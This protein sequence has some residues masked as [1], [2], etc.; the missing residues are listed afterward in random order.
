MIPLISL[1][2]SAAAAELRKGSE[3][4]QSPRS[5]GKTTVTRLTHRP[6]SAP[7]ANFTTVH[8]HQLFRVALPR[9]CLD[10][11]KS[12]NFSTLSITSIFSRLHGVL[13]VGKKITNYTI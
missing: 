9:P 3:T 13:N 12:Q 4:H 10:A 7:T 2:M 5:N 8:V 1:P 6:Y 11:P